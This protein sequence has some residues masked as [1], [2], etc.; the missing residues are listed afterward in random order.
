MNIPAFLQNFP[1]LLWISGMPRSPYVRWPRNDPRKRDSG[2]AEN[3]FGFNLALAIDGYG[4]IICVT[5]WSISWTTYKLAADQDKAL[6]RWE[7]RKG[8]EEVTGSFDI[9]PIASLGSCC[10]IHIS[11]GGQMNGFGG[12]EIRYLSG[13]FFWDEQVSLMPKGLVSGVK[14]GSG[15]KIQYGLISALPA[16]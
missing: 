5:F 6:H 15:I 13:P 14:R 3:H 10:F 12:L 11:P 9:H 1:K 8:L 2:S 4:C 16:C 7:I